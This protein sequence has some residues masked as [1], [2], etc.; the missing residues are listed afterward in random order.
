M[1]ASP[2]VISLCAVIVPPTLRKRVNTFGVDCSNA[3]V[4]HS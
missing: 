4:S 3:P 1:I 2:A